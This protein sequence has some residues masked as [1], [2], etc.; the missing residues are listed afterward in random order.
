MVSG[1][2]AKALHETHDSEQ[3]AKQA[4]RYEM[5]VEVEAMQEE[6]IVMKLGPTGSPSS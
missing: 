1:T 6:V 3:N 5:T 2:F 4:S